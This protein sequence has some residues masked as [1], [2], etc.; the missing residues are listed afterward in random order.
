MK[1]ITEHLCD[2]LRVRSDRGIAKYGVSIDRDDLSLADWLQHASEERADELQ[3]IEAARRRALEMEVAM[4]QAVAFAEYVESAAKGAMV[5][6][7]RHFL[8]LPFA[9]EIAKRLAVTA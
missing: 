7:A 1:P 5:E 6:R 2:Q 9:Q 8:S 4:G 3:Y